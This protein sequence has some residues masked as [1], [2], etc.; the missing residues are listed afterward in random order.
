MMEVGTMQALTRKDVTAALGDLDDITV[1]E[2]LNSGATVD[3]L[4]EAQ[5]WLANDEPLMNIG[6]PLAAGRV[7]R[8]VEILQSVEADEPG[9]L[10]HEV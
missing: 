5:A 6:K 2:I 1:V 4:A 10:G 7:G 8:L 9:P 3:E